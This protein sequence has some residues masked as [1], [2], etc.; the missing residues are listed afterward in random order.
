MIS[1]FIKLLRRTVRPLTLPG[2]IRIGKIGVRGS[3]IE[4]PREILN[5]K[6][7]SIGD[8][9]LIRKNS[10]ILAVT[11]NGGA[12][13]NPEIIIEDDVYIGRYSY[14]TC[15]NKIAIGSRTVISD[16]L[17]LSDTAH[18]IDPRRGHIMMQP[19]ESK[20]PVI[21]GRNCFIGMRVTI[22]PG[23][24]LGDWCVVGAHSVV[25]RSFPQYS[26]V[27]GIPARIIRRYSPETGVWEQVRRADAK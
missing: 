22:M 26:M 7:L 12:R 9:T 18:G 13:C 21:I 3:R 8:G 25:T 19:L 20:G 11:H 23:V 27:A 24:N 1:D 16:Y 17:F 4:F 15:Q 6:H 10:H 14:I 5:G 2:P